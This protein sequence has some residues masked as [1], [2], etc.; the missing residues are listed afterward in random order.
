MPTKADWL[1]ESSSTVASELVVV[2]SLELPGSGGSTND[3]VV[4]V[5]SG[6]DNDGKVG[7]EV[8]KTGRDG[9]V[10]AIMLVTA[11]ANK[12][13]TRICMDIALKCSDAFENL[14]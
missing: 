3:A 1:V 12:Y 14:N 5:E 2:A 4:V 7:R 10:V 13:N 6:D 11:F 9:K 8:D